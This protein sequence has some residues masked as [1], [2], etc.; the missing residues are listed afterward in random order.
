VTVVR[1]HGKAAELRLCLD[2]FVTFSIKRK[3]KEEENSI[4]YS[5]Q[6]LIWSKY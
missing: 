6:N 3:S 5:G 4:S 2:L 1:W